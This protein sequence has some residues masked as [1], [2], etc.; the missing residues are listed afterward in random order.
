[1]GLCSCQNED[2]IRRRL[3]QGLQKSI[4]GSDRKHMHL[5]DNIDLVPSFCRGIGYLIPYLT[6]IVHTII[7]GRINLYHIHGSA[8]RNRTAGC[9]FSTGISVYW[10]LTVYCL[11][12]NLGNGSLSGSSGAAEQIS[13]AYP[14]C[15]D[16]IFQC[17]DY[18]LLALYIAK[19]RRPELPVERHIRHGLI[20][21]ADS[22]HLCLCNNRR[23]GIYKL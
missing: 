13:V 11:C 2:Y 23:I 6:N 21:K 18:M 5:I 17:C 14:F 9:T 10:L 19:L 1:M 20:S 4:K 12:K 8:C 7:G 16:L 22:N 15:L 3:L